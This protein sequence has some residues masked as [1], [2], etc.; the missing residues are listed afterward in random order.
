MKLRSHLNQ[1]CEIGSA[2]PEMQKPKDKPP[3]ES[4]EYLER[5]IIRS[6]GWFK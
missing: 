4:A 1:P 5:Q 2:S 3:S 6:E